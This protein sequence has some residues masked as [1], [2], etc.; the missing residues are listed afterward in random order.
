MNQYFLKF[1][2]KEQAIAAGMLVAD[3]NNGEIVKQTNGYFIDVIGEITKQIDTGQI[4]ADGNKIYQSQVTDG[5]HINVLA[6]ELPD[7]LLQYNIIVDTPY[8]VFAV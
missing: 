5:Y 8:R 3:V 1:A 2:D 4:D 7:E 6:N